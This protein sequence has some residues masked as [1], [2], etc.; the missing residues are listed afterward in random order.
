MMGPGAY[1][2]IIR[3][4]VKNKL[5]G[6]LK[7]EEADMEMQNN[8]RQYPTPQTYLRGGVEDMLRGMEHPYTVPKMENENLY[9][10]PIK[11]S[12]YT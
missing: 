8:P 2:A 3:Q 6:K 5:Y 4:I 9:N 12:P 10:F 7:D 1:D 11:R